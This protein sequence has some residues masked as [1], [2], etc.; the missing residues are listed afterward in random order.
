[1]D[2]ESDRQVDQQKNASTAGETQ[3]SRLHGDGPAVKS[4]RRGVKSNSE[5]SA[6]DDG[7]E[8]GSEECEDDEDESE[9]SDPSDDDPEKL[10]FLRK[11]PAATDYN[12][13]GTLKFQAKSKLLLKIDQLGDSLDA[14]ED[15]VDNSFGEEFSDDEESEEDEDDPEDE[16]SD[17][18]PSHPRE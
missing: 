17:E 6:D 3:P 4:T 13:D 5:E 7:E 11:P 15:D 2:Q 16:R 8:S 9:E 1:M 12:P 14:E 18:S 10:K